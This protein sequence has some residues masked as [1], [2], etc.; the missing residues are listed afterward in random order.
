MHVN[1]IRLRQKGWT[2]EEISHLRLKMRKL[3]KRQAYRP[4]FDAIIFWLVVLLSICAN[5]VVASVFFPFIFFI[6]DISIFFAMALLG[7]IFGWLFATL[8]RDH[9]HNHP[10]RHAVGLAIIIIVS[11]LLIG[12][13]FKGATMPYDRFFLVAI[14]LLFYGIPFVFPRR[15]NGIV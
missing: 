11:L 7:F 14:Y 3:E 1:E 8:A 9:E 6:Q 4:V 15:K 2:T 13:I 5:G 10:L 12:W